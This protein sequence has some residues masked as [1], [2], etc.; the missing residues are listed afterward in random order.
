MFDLIREDLRAKARYSCGGDS[1]KQVLRVLGWDG[2]F[3]TMFYR[4]SQF[5]YRHHLG[6]IGAILSQLNPILTHAVIGRRAQF[7]PGFIILHSIGLV[8]NTGVQGGSNIT[9]ENGVT[10]GAEKGHAPVLGDNVYIGAGARIIGN[11]RVG[12][13]VRIGANAVVVKDVP[14]NA[15]VVGI[16]AR[17]V[18]I[19]DRKIELSDNSK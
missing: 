8:I 5:C 17:V 2:T 7:G 15:T 18:R 19:G 3:A 6:L 12:N 11:V 13:D 9:I 1:L 16:P 14:D 4:A 10:I